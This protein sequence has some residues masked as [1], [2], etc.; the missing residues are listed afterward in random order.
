MKSYQI[1]MVLAIMTASS[2]AIRL[3]SSDDKKACDNSVPSEIEKKAELGV[4]DKAEGKRH[5]IRNGN[6]NGIGS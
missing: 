5:K 4:V 2:Q 6:G 3:N 1:A